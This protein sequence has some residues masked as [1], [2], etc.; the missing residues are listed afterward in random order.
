MGMRA[1]SMPEDRRIVQTVEPIFLQE[2]LIGVLIYEKPALA[3]EDVISPEKEQCQQ[4]GAL[5]RIT[6]RDNGVGVQHKTA[7][8]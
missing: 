1:V 5:G 8:S 2:K 6:V 7:H 4:S 3:V